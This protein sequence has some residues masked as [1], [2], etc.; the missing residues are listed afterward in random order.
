MVLV[1]V[2]SLIPKAAPPMDFPQSDKVA[3]C[4]A[5]AWLAG[6]AAVAWS[7]KSASA[8]GW[9]ALALGIGLEVAQSFVPGRFFSFLDMGAN[10]LGA[11]AGWWLGTRMQR[12]RNQTSSNSS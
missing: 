9:G 5:Y 7:G 6:L 1:T 12:F 3:H 11:G 4:I 8:R 2:L 10:A